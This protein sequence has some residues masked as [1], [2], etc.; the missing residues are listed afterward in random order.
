MSFDWLVAQPIAH[1]GWHGAGRPENSLAAARAACEAGYAIECDI[2]L[3]A[4]GEAM[5]FHDDMLARLT[6]A[7]G[8]L[9][10]H[11]CAALRETALQDTEERI[12]TLADLLAVIADR[13]PLICEIKSGF[14]GD[15]R[16]TDRAAEI[17]GA[18]DGPLAFKSFDPDVIAHL[19][20]RAVPRPLGIVAEADYE[21]PYFAALTP[22]QKRDCKAFLHIGRTAPDFLSWR[23]D[24]FPHAA[25]ALMASS[26]AHR[27]SD[28]CA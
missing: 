10:D 11:P 2:Q 5:V 7:R 15:M 20:A 4:D 3:S 13:T 25:P 22:A 1:R 24:D 8:R 6:R 18:Y 27:C 23:V 14:G 21:D 12:P 28:G 19:R 16:L 26:R 17:A 9:G